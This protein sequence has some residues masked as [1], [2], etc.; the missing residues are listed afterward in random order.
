MILAQP[1]Q[2]GKRMEAIT[3][4]GGTRGCVH[5]VLPCRIGWMRDSDQLGVA[6]IQLA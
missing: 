6:V 1:N 4:M 2:C 5:P 3:V